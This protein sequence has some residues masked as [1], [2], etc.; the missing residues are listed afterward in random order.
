MESVFA[1]SFKPLIILEL[2]DPYPITP[3]T[4]PVNGSVAVPGSKSIT[5]RALIMAALAD[6]VTTLENCLFSEDTEIM[7]QTLS[8]LGFEIVADSLSKTIRV[9]G[10][11]GAIPNKRAELF[12]GN[13]GTSARFLTAFCCLAVDGEYT[14]DGVPQMRKRPIAD[15]AETLNQLGA[16]IDTSDGFFPLRIR[17]RGLKG[18]RAAIDATSSSQFVSALIMVAPYTESGMTIEMANPGVRRGYIGITLAML[19][20][21]GIDPNGIQSSNS[22]YSIVNAAPY[23]SKS[24]GYVIEGDASA[25]S[26]FLALP[27]A[28][29]GVVEILG[30]TKD[31][32]QGDIAFADRMIECGATIEWQQRSTICRFDL[33]SQKGAALSGD[34]YPYSDTF[35]TAAALAP[36]LEGRSSIEGIEHT[37]HQECDRI[38]AM[39]SGL[40]RVG[41]AIEE[42]EGSLAI[43]PQTL[44]PATVETYRDHRVA[45]SF[46]ILG[47]YNALGNGKPWL[48]IEDPSCCRKTFPEFFE[49][50]EA[51]RLQ[52]IPSPNNA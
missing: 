29:G 16:D 5:N 12:V 26:Y 51:L 40:R 2:I 14:L 19:K 18:G 43:A 27:V 7:V 42:S 3:F 52:S 46:G 32:L 49:T 21:F 22:D 41:Q 6:G 38:E 4:T 28:V 30:V 50:L 44:I 15:L 11:A 25:A 47:S 23:E 31:S 35:L 24:L 13:S 45:M 33:R 36:L 8:A 17:A 10:L 37:R 1:T 34:F 20:Q 48:R 9:K 39:A